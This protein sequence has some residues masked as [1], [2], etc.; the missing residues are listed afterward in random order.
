[1]TDNSSLTSIDF[2]TL[3]LVGHNLDLGANNALETLGF[4][5]LTSIGS[6]L[7]LDDNLSLPLCLANRLIAQVEAADD[8]GGRVAISGTRE[9][10]TCSE[11]DGE[12]VADCP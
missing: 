6:E 5:F 4:P 3:I 11:V 10:C 9:D 1:M 2:P 8:T 12:I 7:R